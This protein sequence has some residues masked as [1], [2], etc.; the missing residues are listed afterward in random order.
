MRAAV[1]RLGVTLLY[2]DG[3][4]ENH[5]GLL[6]GLASQSDL[7]LFPVDC[8]SHDAAQAVKSLCRQGGK[9]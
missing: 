3:G 2:H 1:E 4:I 7:V 6:P 5:A 8:I 9:R